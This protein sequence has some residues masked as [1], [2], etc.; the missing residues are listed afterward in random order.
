MIFF[1]QPVLNAPEP[2]WVQDIKKEV[3]VDQT[4]TRREAMFSA[5]G[6]VMDAIKPH[7]ADKRDALMI[8]LIW[9]L[10]VLIVPSAVLQYNLPAFLQPYPVAVGCAHLV[11]V[12]VFFI[13]RFILCLHYSEH[14]R[15]FKA[16]SPLV[17]AHA[18][19][20]YI[21]CN[22]FGIPGGVYRLHHVVMHHLE[23]NMFPEDLSST[24]PYQRDNFLHFLHYWAKFFFA[25]HVELPLY[26]IRAK[27]C[28]CPPYPSPSGSCCAV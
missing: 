23:D 17:V 9:N 14:K 28:P 21:L 15:L 7:L 26:A 13:Q 24:M 6:F 22:F 10:T 18:Y 4:A 27:R 8:D 25:I 1:V 12:Y 2:R 5:P 11:L 3:K 20:P 19:L 16:S